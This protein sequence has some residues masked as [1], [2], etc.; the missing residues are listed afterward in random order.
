M[1]IPKKSDG[2]P[3]PDAAAAAKCVKCKPGCIIAGTLVGRGIDD[4]VGVVLCGDGELLELLSDLIQFESINDFVVGANILSIVNNDVDEEFVFVSLCWDVN[5]CMDDD[6]VDDEVDVDDDDDWGV[7]DIDD[8]DDADNNIWWWS[9][10]LWR[11]LIW[12]CIRCPKYAAHPCV[13]LNNIAAVVIKFVF[14]GVV[15][16]V[17]VVV[18]IVV[19]CITFIGLSQ[20][21]FGP[22]EFDSTIDDG[23]S[24]ELFGE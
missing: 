10:S 21:L 22:D 8:V 20:W 18:I 19:P 3:N 5:D 7:G 2:V 9:F 17:F 16:V 4:D 15:V 23:L 24:M 13:L 14:V 12:F 11:S 1:K 6:S